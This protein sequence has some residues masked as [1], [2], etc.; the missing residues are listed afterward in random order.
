MLHSYIL[1]NTESAG[2]SLDLDL[3]GKAP[4]GRLVRAEAAGTRGHLGP[5]LSCWHLEGPGAQPLSLGQS[6]HFTGERSRERSSKACEEFV[7]SSWFQREATAELWN[8][9]RSESRCRL[10]P[11]GV[12]FFFSGSVGL[13]PRWTNAIRKAKLGRA[14]DFS[15]FSSAFLF[16]EVSQS[17]VKFWLRIPV[18]FYSFLHP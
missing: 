2:L 14:F 17:G 8:Q 16:S 7:I 10:S 11:C 15:E 18:G 4:V 3:G 6:L 1:I 5:V 9:P 12:V 13:A